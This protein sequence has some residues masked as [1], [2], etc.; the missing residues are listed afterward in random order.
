MQI[1]VLNTGAN[2]LSGVT[3]LYAPATNTILY[4]VASSQGTFTSVNGS[5][6]FNLGLL[7]VGQ[8]AQIG[9]NFQPIHSGTFIH[10]F[11]VAAD[12]PVLGT[13]NFQFSTT[14]NL[15]PVMT[16][17]AASNNAV[18]V[19]W[20][21]NDAWTLQQNNQLTGPWSNAPVQ[22]SPA[23]LPANQPSQFFRLKQP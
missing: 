20:P 15:I 17:A 7:P 5:V 4:N 18:T 6:A 22:S 19:S 21:T 12:Q 8:A 13:T 10:Q 11:S 2:D 16:L 9:I 14:V 1:R 3:V 23:T